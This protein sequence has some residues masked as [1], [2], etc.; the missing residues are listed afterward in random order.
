MEA[1]LALLKQAQAPVADVSTTPNPS[2]SELLISALRMAEAKQ[3][4]ETLLQSLTSFTRDHADLGAG[5]TNAIKE[6]TT[7]SKL[8]TDLTRKTLLSNKISSRIP[9]F[10]KDPS[11]Y[12]WEE[13]MAHIKL[14]GKRG[15]YDEE[16]MKMLI[17]ESLEG[18]AF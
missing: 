12:S 8:P 6:L 10:G 5:I 18:D 2:G 14:A 15:V 13:Y 7:R 1:E 17:Q 4:T 11:T 16:E 9:K 3:M